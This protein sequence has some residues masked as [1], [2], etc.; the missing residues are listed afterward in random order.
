MWSSWW[1]FARS[2]SAYV[3]ANMVIAGGSL[4][5]GLTWIGCGMGAG[6]AGSLRRE[7]CGDAEACRHLDAA[8]QLS[9]ALC[10]WLQTEAPRADGGCG[11]LFTIPR[12]A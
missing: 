7:G 2:I 3:P 6:A 1:R 8:R 4:G 12:R 11:Y 10:Y 9:L 5:P